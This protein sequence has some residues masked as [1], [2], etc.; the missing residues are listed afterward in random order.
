MAAL[1]HDRALNAAMRIP[2]VSRTLFGGAGQH[3]ERRRSGSSQWPSAPGRLAAA[4]L[5]A[6]LRPAVLVEVLAEHHVVRD[7]E[8]VDP[9]PV[10][11]LRGG[12]HRRPVVG[13]SAANAYQRGGELRR[14]RW[15]D[16]FGHDRDGPRS[17]SAVEVSDA[18]DAEQ[19]HRPR[20]VGPKP[21]EDPV[22]T[23]LAAAPSA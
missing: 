21:L 19:V 23:P 4:L 17:R 2:V 13:V 7:H 6:D 11:A 18:R 3:A 22:H 12:V 15:H 20:N 10:V 9:G 16:E 8:P 1:E 5:A 14:G